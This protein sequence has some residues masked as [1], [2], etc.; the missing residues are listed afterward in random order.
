MSKFLGDTTRKIAQGLNTTRLGPGGKI[1]NVTN[2]KKMGVSQTSKKI[3]IKPHQ[4]T[5]KK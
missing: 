4:K 5:Q 1:Q 3:K 2:T